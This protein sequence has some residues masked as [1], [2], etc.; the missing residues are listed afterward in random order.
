MTLPPSPDDN[1]IGYIRVIMMVGVLQ[2]IHVSDKIQHLK[3]VGLL[4]AC[5]K[6]GMDE[7]LFGLCLELLKHSVALHDHCQTFC[8]PQET[9][10]HS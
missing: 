6:E 4:N 1:P 5:A 3:L 2:G 7:P 8:L 9:T 10:P